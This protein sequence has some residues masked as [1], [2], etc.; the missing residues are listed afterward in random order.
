[1]LTTNTELLE[2]YKL[3]YRQLTGGVHVYTDGEITSTIL[4]EDKLVQFTIERTAPNGKFFGYV[5]IQKLVIEVLG[6]YQLSK[7]TQLEPFVFPWDA[8]DT[9]P[10]PYFYVDTTDYDKVNKKTTITAYDIL[11]R[12]TAIMA[13]TLELPARYTLEEYA[14]LAF[15]AIGAEAETLLTMAGAS[16]MFVTDWEYEF[17]VKEDQPLNVSGKETI[18]DMLVALAEATGAIAYVN[19]GNYI[20]WRTRQAF[21]NKDTNTRLVKDTLYPKDYFDFTYKDS[22]YLTKVA[23]ANELGDNVEQGDDSGFTQVLWD[24]PFISLRTDQEEVMTNLTYWVM[25]SL[26]TDFTLKYRG[27]PFYQIG[28]MYAIVTPEGDTVLVCYQNDTIT[29]N[30]GLSGVMS[31]TETESENINGN[32]VSLGVNLKNTVAKVDKFNN[33]IVLQAQKIDEL[34]ESVGTLKVKSDSIEASVTSIDNEM[35]ELTKTVSTAVSEENVQILI[36]KQLAITEVDSVRTKTGFTFDEEGLLIERSDSEIS[37]LITEDGMNVMKN[38]QIQL[39]ADSRGV[40]AKDLHA[41]TY[42]LIG[43]NS[44]LENYNYSRTGCFWIGE[45]PTT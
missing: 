38:G 27:N 11:N 44:R 9:A 16:T 17:T 22:I 26:N 40:T 23:F 45:L 35:K 43:E 41:T 32:P 10:L 7:G 30:G 20:N 2:P 6:N 8:E 1:M 14:H 24:N 36:E 28:D 34:G 25:Q 29:Y 15:A 21:G 12:A 37:T 42:L 19:R 4:P 31:W 13:N 33:E 5:M 3:P 18:Y 39:S